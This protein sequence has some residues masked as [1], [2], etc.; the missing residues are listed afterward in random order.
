[1]LAGERDFSLLQ[2]AQMHYWTHSISWVLF[3]RYIDHS[4]P[5][6]TM[7]KNEWNYTSTLPIHLDMDSNN[8]PFTCY[9]IIPL[10][11]CFKIWLGQFSPARY[12][13]LIVVLLRSQLFGCNVLL[14][15]QGFLTF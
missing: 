2:N 5:S 13:F 14:L 12:E 9:L 4:P 8:C 11:W 10:L 7:V 1:M 3:C 6:S 15:D